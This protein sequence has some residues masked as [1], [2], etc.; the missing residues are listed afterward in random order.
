MEQQM[1]RRIL[2]W[3][4]IALLAVGFCGNNS[5][6]HPLEDGQATRIAPSAFIGRLYRHGD[7]QI[8]GERYLDCSCP[9]NI[10]SGCPIGGGW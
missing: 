9:K 1:G 5:F 7:L 2:R 8:S 4:T 6:A 3:S 10:Q